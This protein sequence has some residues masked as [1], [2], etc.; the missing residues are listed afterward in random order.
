M[1]FGISIQS[2]YN[3]YLKYPVFNKNKKNETC[4]EIGKCDP[5]TGKKAGNRSRL[6]EGSNVRRYRLQ[7]S[8]YV[9]PKN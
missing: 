8:Q 3:I 6:W 2:Y 5:C 4:K 9:C 7:G 1:G